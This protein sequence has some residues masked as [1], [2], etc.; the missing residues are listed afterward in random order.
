MRARACSEPVF[1]GSATCPGEATEVNNCILSD[2]PDTIAT[3]WQAWGEWSPCTVSCGKGAEFRARACNK[4]DVG[5]SQSCPGDSTEARDCNLTGCTGK[6]GNVTGQCTAGERQT[7]TTYADF[8]DSSFTF[9]NDSIQV[10]C[11][12]PDLTLTKVTC[13]QGTSCV[14][15]CSAIGASLCLRRSARRIL[16]TATSVLN[17]KSRKKEMQAHA[18]HASPL[19]NSGSVLPPVG[20]K[21]N[22]PAAFTLFAMKRG[23]I[24]AATPITSPVFH[25]TLHYRLRLIESGH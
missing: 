13:G 6:E 15:Q 4:P 20:S 9:F 12:A 25:F 2:C 18:K 8:F 3:E 16:T 7:S 22:P 1:G 5:G 14:G 21:E 10:G 17:Q 24:I 19:R 11:C 23:Q